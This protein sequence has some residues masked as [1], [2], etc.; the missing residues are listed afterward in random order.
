[1]PFSCRRDSHT[2]VFTPSDILLLPGYPRAIGS[3]LEVG[4]GLSFPDPSAGL[5]PQATLLSI[6]LAMSPALAE[7]TGTYVVGI[8]VWVADPEER[9]L[10]LAA[11]LGT[12][13]PAA[14]LLLLF[15][16]LA[17]G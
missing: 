7:R 2:V 12:A 3:S 16:A 11:I 10:G 14:L 15:T 13:I 8:S 1:M 5:V 17:V 6:S 4:F 9:G